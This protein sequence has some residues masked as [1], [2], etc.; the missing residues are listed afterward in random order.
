MPPWPERGRAAARWTS[1][2]SRPTSTKWWPKSAARQASR[3]P[4][5]GIMTLKVFRK[6]VRQKR[7]WGVVPRPEIY[8]TI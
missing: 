1:T 5:L 3:G 8:D 2:S 4:S 7:D 6:V